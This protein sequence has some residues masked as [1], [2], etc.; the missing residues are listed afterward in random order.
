VAYRWHPLHGQQAVQRGA[1]QVCGQRQ[2]MCRLADGAS[3]EVPEWMLEAGTCAQHTEGP[4]QVDLN[5]LREVQR[6]LCAVKRSWVCDSQ[7]IAS[8]SEGSLGEQ[9]DSSHSADAASVPCD[10]SL[11]DRAAPGA[12][13]L[14][15]ESAAAASRSD[16]APR[17]PRPAGNRS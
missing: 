17:S 12:G 2:A 15:S 8:L 11:P 1:K 13:A 4:P 16:R 3:Y 14:R 10:G 9:T 6:V 5:A 7:G